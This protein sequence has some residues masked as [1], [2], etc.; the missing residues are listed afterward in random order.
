M[1]KISIDTSEMVWNRA[2]YRYEIRAEDFAKAVASAADGVL[3][4]RGQM[5]MRVYRLARI[6]RDETA[7]ITSTDWL[8][9]YKNDSITGEL[10][11]IRIFE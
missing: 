8:W 2:E 10:E 11:P 1:K 4:V 9:D 6:N 5:G 3:L 7:K